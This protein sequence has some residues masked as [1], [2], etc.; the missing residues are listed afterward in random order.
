MSNNDAP[1]IPL[2]SAIETRILAALMEKELTTPDNYPLTLNSLT[3]AC[4]QKSNREPVM[5]LTQG[6]VGHVLNHLEL[7]KLVRID[8]GERALRVAQQ[9]RP[10]LNLDRKAQAI[11]SVLMLRAPQ[12]V[13]ELRLRTQRMVE[14]NDAAEILDSLER[15]AGATPPLVQCLPKGPGR[16]EDRY[17]HLLCG[18]L[19]ISAY[20]TQNA[21]PLAPAAPHAIGLLEE[22]V[23]ALEA[24]VARLLDRL[25]TERD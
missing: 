11:L 19:D 13:N 5:N 17:S 7:Q 16:R 3:L 22:R 21:D 2:L 12:T 10:A 8:R 4:N 1:A 24:Q 25:G 20:E 9:L 14:F 23:S 6:K 15:M 18:E